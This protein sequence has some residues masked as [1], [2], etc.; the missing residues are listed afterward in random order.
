MRILVTGARGKV[1]A[2]AVDRLLNRGHDDTPTDR[3]P[4]L[5]QGGGD[6]SVPYLQADLADAGEAFGVLRDQDAVVHAAAIPDPLPS[7]SHVVSANTLLET[8]N[9]LGAA[10]RLGVG[11]VVHA[12]SE[13][14]PGFF[15]PQR[16]FLAAYAPVDE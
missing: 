1:G 13:T 16:P 8:F 14:V 9:V 5:F 10:V 11:R 6:G 15:F 12:S 2:A 3:T 4:P 7:A